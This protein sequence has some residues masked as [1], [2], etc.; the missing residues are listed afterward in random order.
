MPRMRAFD[1]SRLPPLKSLSPAFFRATNPH[2]TH[3]EFEAKWAAS[4]AASP[5]M[6]FR[7]FPQAYHLDLTWAGR[8]PG[9]EGFCF[10]DPHPENF[11]LQCFGDKVA[12][13]FNDLDDSGPALVFVDALRYFTATVLQDELP[14]AK[15]V[16][17]YAEVVAHGRQAVK[18]PPTWLPAATDIV[19]NRTKKYLKATGGFLPDSRLQAASPKVRTAFTDAAKRLYGPRITVHDIAQRHRTEGG[20]GG[21]QRIWA[22]LTVNR[23]QRLVEFKE[24]AS[25]ATSWGR[26]LLTVDNRV[27]VA[28]AKLWPHP[29]ADDH[30]VVRLGTSL[31]LARDRLR[32]QRLAFTP[33]QRETV[34]FAQTT[35][36]AQAHRAH[37]PRTATL[38]QWLLP[39]AR[40]LAARWEKAQK[41]L[42]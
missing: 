30:L 36:L 25:P 9:G 10:G 5:L 21:L 34:A 39:A 15:L 18:V 1:V 13:V 19:E 11:G 16:R 24:L 32:R 35:I 31:F 41:Q 26:E 17:H 20:S 37:W 4:L 12:Y 14:V 2:L 27:E 42:R 7:A 33:A 3:D 8:L 28:K 38:P 29:L 40:A 6:F 23:L 22:R